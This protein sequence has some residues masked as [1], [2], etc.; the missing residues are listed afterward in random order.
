MPIGRPTAIESA[1]LLTARGLAECRCFARR[2]HAEFRVKLT[3]TPEIKMLGKLILASVFMVSLLSSARAHVTLEQREAHIAAPYKAVFR[4]PHG[5]GTSAT[6]KVSVRIPQGVIGVKPMPK[7]GWQLETV[8]GSYDK[9][10]TLFHGTVSEG[11]KEVIWT[12]RL[13]DEHYDEFVLSTFLTDDLV[14]GRNLYFPA[15]Q[16]CESGVNRWIEIP[17]EGRTEADLKEPA[18]RLMLLP[19][20]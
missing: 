13:A 18:P 9:T 5:C 19:K 15:V 14:P 7:P 12:G 16:E 1:R 11:V 20:R 6:V 3:Y 17:A 4:V 8:R 10:Y 2:R